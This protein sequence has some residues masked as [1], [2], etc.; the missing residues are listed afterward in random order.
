MLSFWSQLLCWWYGHDSFYDP[1][2]GGAGACLRC[3]CLLPSN[4]P[5][6]GEV[7]KEEFNSL[8]EQ[9]KAEYREDR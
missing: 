8:R 9:I 4:K 6:Y 5:F 1:A 2:W 7:S 3:K